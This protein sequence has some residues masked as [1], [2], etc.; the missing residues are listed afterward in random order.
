MSKLR[1]I[2]IE[3]NYK[4][5]TCDVC[6]KEE[7]SVAEVGKDNKV[8]ICDTCAEQI[9]GIHNNMKLMKSVSS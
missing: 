3:F 2:T 8:A 6:G 5:G 7:V 1:Q 9:G 4:K